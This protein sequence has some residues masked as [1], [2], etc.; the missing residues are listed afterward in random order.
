MYIFLHLILYPKYGSWQVA[1]KSSRILL[2]IQ[3]V[4]IQL[5]PT[6]KEKETGGKGR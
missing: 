4:R 6:G 3:N 5:R 2:E 1:V